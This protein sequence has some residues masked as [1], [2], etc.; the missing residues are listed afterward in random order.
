MATGA[1]TAPLVC[2]ARQ[3][4]VQLHR[5]STQH[6]ACTTWLPWL[7]VPPAYSAIKVGGRKGYKAARAGQ[8]LEI[9]PRPRHVSEFRVW[10]DDPS[11][12]EVAYH[13]RCGK[14]TYVRSLVHD[15]VRRSTQHAPLHARTHCLVNV[16]QL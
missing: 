5:R 3:A 8:P 6:A 9:A 1:L 7:Q 14:G 13:I 4:G 11:A 16:L 2:T 15:L 10:R 12:Q